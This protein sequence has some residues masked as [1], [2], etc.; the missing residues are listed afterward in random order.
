MHEHHRGA[1][2]VRHYHEGGDVAH[3]HDD[4]PGRWRYSGRS[5]VTRRPVQLTAEQCEAIA[6]AVAAHERW[7][8]APTDSGR[9]LARR[10]AIAAAVDGAGATTTA[11]AAALG[12][13]RQQVHRL[14][15]A[16]RAS[17]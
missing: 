17:T 11:V 8:A 9:A 7:Q 3:Q 4:L 1:R 6:A 10:R 14:A 15:L 16:G 2:L 12:L 5:Y 13:S